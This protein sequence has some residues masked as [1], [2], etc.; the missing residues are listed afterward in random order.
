MSDVSFVRTEMLPPKDPPASEVGALG[1][2]KTNLFSSVFNSILTVVSAIFIAY[3]V[4]GL[5][6]WALVPSWSMTSLAE[7]RALMADLG[8]STHNG[9]ACWG[10]MVVIC[11]WLLLVMRRLFVD[12]RADGEERQAGC[13]GL[14]IVWFVVARARGLKR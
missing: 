9:G 1:W 8:R 5:L 7:C 3:V 12:A 2:A 10:V 4:F 11:F 13:L 6:S 14:Q